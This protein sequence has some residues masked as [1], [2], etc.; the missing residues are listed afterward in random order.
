MLAVSSAGRCVDGQVLSKGC[1]SK[2]VGG[3]CWV[4]CCAVE[5][6]NVSQAARNLAPKGSTRP[7]TPRLCLSRRTSFANSIAACRPW[8]YAFHCTEHNEARDL[9]DVLVPG[10]FPKT[11][12]PSRAGVPRGQGSWGNSQEQP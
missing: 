8:F 9:R 4:L 5:V 7:T 2:V 3:R 10:S 1:K 12:Q 11:P 6:A